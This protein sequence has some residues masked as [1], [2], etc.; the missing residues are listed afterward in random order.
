MAK[1]LLLHHH[2]QRWVNCS[3]VVGTAEEVACHHHLRP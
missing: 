2:H 1:L 3:S